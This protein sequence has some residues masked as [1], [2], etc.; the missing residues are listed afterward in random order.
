[1]TSTTY[2]VRYETGLFDIVFQGDLLDRKTEEIVR[3]CSNAHWA[4]IHDVETLV[5]FIRH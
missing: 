5:I 1:M 2:P 3:A 4:R